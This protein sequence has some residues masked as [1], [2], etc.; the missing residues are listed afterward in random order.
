MEHWRA[1]FAQAEADL[2]TII[3]QAILVAAADFPAEF[4]ERRC[5]IAE[6]LFARRPYPSPPAR[7]MEVTRLSGSVIT[8]ATA[9]ADNGAHHMCRQ[10]VNTQRY[11]H[12]SEGEVKG[13]DTHSNGS[14][15]KA[16][17]VDRHALGHGYRSAELDTHL[18]NHDD[19][20]VNAHARDH[21]DVDM[22][23]S[24]Q[25]N[26]SMIKDKI[27]DATNQSEDEILESLQALEHL[28]INV[29][30]LKATDIGREVNKFRKH[31]SGS[32]RILAKQLVRTW[33][34]MVDEWVKNAQGAPPL[35][36]SG[37]QGDGEGI[38]PN[39][40]GEASLISTKTSMQMPKQRLHKSTGDGMARTQSRPQAGALPSCNGNF[41]SPG[42]KLY[43]EHALEEMG[44]S[45]VES[46]EL[47]RPGIVEK[48]AE[49][50]SHPVQVSRWMVT[51]SSTGGSGPGRPVA[52]I[53]E[54]NM[55][56]GHEKISIA[57]KSSAVDHSQPAERPEITKRWFP[58]ESQHAEHA[59]K[60]RGMQPS[61]RPEISKGVI[62]SASAKSQHCNQKKW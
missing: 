42:M 47:E 1:F 31:S 24:I 7:S 60:Q 13:A 23:H 58:Y 34:A 38:R 20:K 33:K 3:D 11:V 10:E 49:L 41:S 52:S 62:V 4:K 45:R 36:A 59:K 40:Q 21:H 19:S 46:D 9:D 8:N 12:V 56:N 55:S 14:D 22:D 5:A 43:S 50:S 48:K 26:V 35:D 27:M 28:E 18:H 25:K 37:I 57:H 16:S 6:T 44:S 54:V 17:V 51:K 53:P 32:V 39:F 30:I 29:K 15:S 61:G 2:W